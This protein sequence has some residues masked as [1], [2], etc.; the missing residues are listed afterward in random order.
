[1]AKSLT[2]E[3]EKLA[4]IKWVTSLKDETAIEN[5]KMLRDKTTPKN[6]WN[7]ITEEEQVIIDNGLANAKAG[8]IKSHK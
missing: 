7:E 2:L 6:W 4:L 3:K 8:R 5:L 1:M